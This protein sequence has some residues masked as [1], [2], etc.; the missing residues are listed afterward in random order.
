MS[1]TC[2]LHSRGESWY[3]EQLKVEESNVH[4]VSENGI[5]VETETLLVRSNGGSMQGLHSN[6]HAKLHSSFNGSFIGY[7]DQKLASSMI[8]AGTN[9]IVV[10]C[11]KNFIYSLLLF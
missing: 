6:G 4:M 5:H 2:H 7:S 9:C 1:L 3:P 8:E 10:Q 11:H